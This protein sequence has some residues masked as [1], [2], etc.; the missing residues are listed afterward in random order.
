MVSELV[1][2]TSRSGSPSLKV[3]GTPY[4]SEYDPLREVRRFCSTLPIEGADVI[5]L[6]GWGLGYCGEALQP[7][8]KENARVV[9]FEPDAAL[10][11]LSRTQTDNHKFLQDPRFHFVVGDQI[12]HF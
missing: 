6:F 8:L 1:V 7:R 4:Y 2:F 9:V 5:L 10:F 11:K 3:N 12:C